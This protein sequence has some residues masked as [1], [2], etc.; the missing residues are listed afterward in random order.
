MHKVRE[1]LWGEA[2]ENG[3]G[4]FLKI[5]CKFVYISTP[6]EL[7]FSISLSLMHQGL[8]WPKTNHECHCQWSIWQGFGE[9]FGA[10]T[11]SLKTAGIIASMFLLVFLLAGGYYVQVI[12][13][14]QWCWRK[15]W[16]IHLIVNFF[17]ELFF[18]IHS[19]F[20]NVGEFFGGVGTWHLW[21]RKCQPSWSGWSTC[22]LYT[23]AFDSFRK[24]NILLTR[25]SIVTLL[26]GAR[27]LQMLEP[28]KACRWIPGSKK[29]GCWCWWQLGIASY[30][31]FVFVA[32]DGNRPS[33]RK[34]EAP[35][36]SIQL[37]NCLQRP[38]RKTLMTSMAKR[39]AILVMTKSLLFFKVWYHIKSLKHLH[40]QQNNDLYTI[41]LVSS[42]LL[43]STK[44]SIGWNW[45]LE[46]VN[47]HST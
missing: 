28:C 39:L 22:L 34:E 21:N 40:W 37:F 20:F 9:M 6:K 27:A 26:A 24:Y 16:K 15:D 17:S 41:L 42:L 18:S 5:L 47:M 4:N 11:L 31:I 10:A 36:K 23:T 30:P 29:L 1:I 8:D 12:K 3:L 19:N 43:S 33:T 14:L 2:T 32:F 25:C 35:I 13:S 45:V 44:L 38:C 7:Q 46:F